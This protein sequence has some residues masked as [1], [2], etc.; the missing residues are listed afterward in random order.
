M[1]GRFQQMECPLT[2]GNM[3]IT[4]MFYKGGRRKTRQNAGAG[5]RINKN[6]KLEMYRVIPMTQ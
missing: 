3:Y 1:K 4:D 2:N 5:M 6:C